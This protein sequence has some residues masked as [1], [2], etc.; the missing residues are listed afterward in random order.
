MSLELLVLVYV[1]FNRRRGL[2]FWSIIITALGF[3]LQI[4]GYLLK[5]YE[6]NWPR[7]LVNIIFTVGRVSNVTGFSIVLWSRLHLLISNRYYMLQIILGI[8]IFDSIVMHIPTIIFRFY[9]MSPQY[10]KQFVHPLEMME[11]VQQTV[12]AL[13]ETAI[14]SLYIYY[15]SSFL[16]SSFAPPRRKVIALR[17]LIAVQVATILMD[18]GLTTFDYLSL[19]TLKCALHPFVYAVKLKMEFVVLNQLVAVVKN[20]VLTTPL[21]GHVGNDQNTTGCPQSGSELF[22]REEKRWPRTK[23]AEM[24]KESD[25]SIA[26]SAT[27]GKCSPTSSTRILSSRSFTVESTRSFGIW[28]MSPAHLTGR[29]LTPGLES[30]QVTTV[31]AGLDHDKCSPTNYHSS[32]SIA[33]EA[34]TIPTRRSGCDERDILNMIGSPDE[35]HCIY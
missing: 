6:N 30:S 23:Q 28:S 32:S 16:R 26:G 3:I 5:F 11:R 20:R 1:T 14:S 12:F 35:E 10:R 33:T 22:P 15:A 29:M 21:G 13:Q 19:Y 25:P 7:V 17:L 34:T 9:M 8:I 2:Y 18:V 31:S 24:A 4:A 27:S